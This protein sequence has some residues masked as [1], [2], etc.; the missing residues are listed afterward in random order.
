[1][2]VNFPKSQSKISQN[3]TCCHNTRTPEA[4]SM[5]DFPDDIVVGGAVHRDLELVTDPPTGL[6]AA[7]FFSKALVLTET[8]RE[9]TLKF[10]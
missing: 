4:D 2:A 5:A 10:R 7:L 3:L 6:V 9:S 1:M 8:S